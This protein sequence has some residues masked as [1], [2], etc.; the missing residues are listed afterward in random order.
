MTNQELA[1]KVKELK[2]VLRK[3]R[4]DLEMRQSWVKESELKIEAIE[5]EI[6]G[7]EA[8]LKA[9]VQR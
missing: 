2:E 5:N 4:L 1:N 7:L 6:A 9:E 3:E 8:E